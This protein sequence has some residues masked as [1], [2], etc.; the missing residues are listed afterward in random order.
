ML[1]FPPPHMA[2]WPNVD[3][4]LRS[5]EVSRSCTMTQHSW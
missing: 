1:I 5:L 2:V 4:G 3:D